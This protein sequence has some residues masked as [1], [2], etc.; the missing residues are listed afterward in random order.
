MDKCRLC[1]EEKYLENLCNFRD[2]EW[3]IEI[4]LETVF[5]IKL[6][7]EKLMPQ[8]CCFECISKLDCSLEFFK[9]IKETQ[10]SLL[11]NLNNQLLQCENS[12]EV[13][14]EIKIEVIDTEL[15][16]PP[17]LYPELEVYSSNHLK[18]K[19]RRKKLQSSSE[20]YTNDRCKGTRVE[21]IFKNEI[22]GIYESQPETLDLLE[23]EKN[24]DGTITESGLLRIPLLG[25][26]AYI[27]RCV[28][29]KVSIDSSKSLEAHFKIEHTKTKPIYPCMDCKLSF[30][31][32]F[33]FQNHV[34]DNHKP[35]LKFSCDVCS[36]FRWNLMSLYNHR[37]HLHPKYKNTCLYCGRLFESGFSLK[38]H[39]SVHMKFKEDELFFC[40]ICGFQAHTKFLIK[41]HIHVFHLKINTEWVCEQCGKICKRLSDMRS[42]QLVHTSERPYG[43]NHCEL[44]FKCKKQLRCHER[45]HFARILKEECSVCLKRFLTKSKLTRHFKVHTDD[46][47]YTW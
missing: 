47:E 31:S 28:V 8:C 41:Q 15:V 14:E 33:S 25:W 4:K 32:Y 2:P 22:N 38:Q 27:W 20:N 21:D 17:L 18:I 37:R 9:R 23:S 24:D 36:E 10:Q 42:H 35:N 11:E 3:M 29:C 19:K 7:N 46:Y 5:N 43:C 45:T 30:K 40:D 16:A 1:G 13:K 39:V 26:S 6:T 34:I 12:F 44:R